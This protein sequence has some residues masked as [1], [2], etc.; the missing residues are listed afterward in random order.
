[1]QIEQLKQS[2][3][4]PPWVLGCEGILHW[5]SQSSL[6]C[7]AKIA[8]SAS[9]NSTKDNTK[10]PRLRSPNGVMWFREALL[11]RRPGQGALEMPRRYGVSTTLF[12]LG[13]ENEWACHVVW[14]ILVLSTCLAPSH[15]EWM[16]PFCWTGMRHQGWPQPP[17]LR[18]DCPDQPW[19]GVD[20]QLP[21]LRSL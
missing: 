7:R 11:L 21:R 1:M 18:F 3:D 17:V 6:P 14:E 9:C 12:G 5:P 13:R 20:W 16:L 19:A 8:D 10:P 4:K 15:R 2:C